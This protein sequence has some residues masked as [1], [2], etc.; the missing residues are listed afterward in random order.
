MILEP[1]VGGDERVQPPFR[2]PPPACGGGVFSLTTNT[3]PFSIA[4]P[5]A[6]VG[7]SRPQGGAKCAGVGST[8]NFP[9]VVLTK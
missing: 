7:S 5:F 4:C 6:E 9:T 8:D 3:L 2:R 1:Q